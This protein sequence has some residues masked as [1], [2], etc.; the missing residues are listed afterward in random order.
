MGTTWF[1]LLA[2]ML[3]VYAVLDGFDLGAG[4]LHLFL[5]H[6]DRER[7]TVIASIGPVWDGNEVWLIASGGLLVF[8][9]PRVYAAAF[10]GFYLPLVIVLWLLILRGVSIELRS[11]HANTLWRQFFDAVFAGSSAILALVLGVALG[12]VLRGV[13]L[14]ASQFF[15]S[16][17]FRGWDHDELGAIDGYTTS[18]GLLAVA[19][20]G[21]HGAMYLR[22]KTSDQLHARATS[23]ARWLW[24]AACVLAVLVLIETAFVRPA[25]LAHIAHRPAL[26][27]V[28]AIAIAAI[29]CVFVA[30]ARGADFRGFAASAL[31]I[32]ALL[33]T[34]AIAL[35]PALLPSTIDPRF[36][37]DVATAANDH[38]G[39]AIGLAW[40][41]PAIVLAL[42]Y[43]T[44]L[45]RAFRG[46]TEPGVDYH[47]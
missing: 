44:Y 41:I 46:K 24:I 29:I 5:A 16:S 13:P 11:H 47:A 12:N 21:A 31:A 45:F 2:F 42:G 39:L 1:I 38:R 22:W 17:L 19:V 18:V 35:Y 25:L 32:A 9:F 20:L 8:A 26:W 6:D 37:L 43:F 30:L 40:W 4:I 14:D 10:S 3:I 27:L 33:A 36:D 7:T 28:P 34:V 15:E 23:A